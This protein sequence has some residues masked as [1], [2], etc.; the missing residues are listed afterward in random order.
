MSYTKLPSLQHIA[1]VIR[2]SVADTERELHR[3]D[4][5]TPPVNYSSAWRMARLLY[6]GDISLRAALDACDR[7][8]PSP[9]AR[10]NAEVVQIIWKDAQGAEYLCRPLKDR[11]FAIR[12]DLE[13]PVRPKFYFVKNGVVYIFWLQPWKTFDLS[14]VQL[15]V[16]ASVI[17]LVFAVDD[18]EDAKLYLLDTSAE[19]NGLRHP[20][21]FG[22][23]DLPLL[24]ADELKSTLGRFATA[25]D[26]FVANR[27]PKPERPRRRPDDR[28]SDLFND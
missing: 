5:S 6:S 26:A 28:Q 11:F 17:K 3:I 21:V 9:N 14:T 25:Y 18:F 27:R 10:C 19:N 15:G 8:K 1:K 4:Q 13:I 7:L 22:F 23:H 2:P 12:R 20:E 24:S 16:L